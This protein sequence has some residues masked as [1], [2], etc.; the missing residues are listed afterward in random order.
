MWGLVII[1]SANHSKM[2]VVHFHFFKWEWPT[3][4]RIPGRESL[5]ESSREKPGEKSREKMKAK[6]IEIGKTVFFLF[7]SLLSLFLKNRDKERPETDRE[8]KR[9]REKPTMTST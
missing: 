5:L 1:Y 7:T 3:V 6:K 8:R 2:D 9:E 4:R